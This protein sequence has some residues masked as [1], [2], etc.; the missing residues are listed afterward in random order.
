MPQHK[1]AKK[2]VKT[3]LKCQARN[4]SA[5]STLR[6]SLKGIVELK[7][8][9]KDAAIRQH[10]SLVDRA[11]NSGLVHPNKA[12]RLKSRLAKSTQKSS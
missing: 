12:A 2:R 7:Q 8:S 4:R 6:S 1:S 10:Q 9:D 11:S 3:N 5:R